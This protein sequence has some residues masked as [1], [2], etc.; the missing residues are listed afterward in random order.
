MLKC[1]KQ[2]ECRGGGMERAR[3]KVDRRSI[4]EEE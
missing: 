3:V 4:D 1:R 2:E